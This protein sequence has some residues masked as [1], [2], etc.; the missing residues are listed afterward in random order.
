MIVD[1]LGECLHDGRDPAL[2]ISF[3]QVII[4]VEPR[5]RPVTITEADLS[6]FVFDYHR[7]QYIA[8]V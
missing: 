2:Q 1:I 3:L 4:S 5:S 6:V 8:A 7:W